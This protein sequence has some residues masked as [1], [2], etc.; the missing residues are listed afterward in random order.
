MCPY[1]FSAGDLG[2]RQWERMYL[3]FFP[4]GPRREI[5][6]NVLEQIIGERQ[7]FRWFSSRKDAHFVY[8]ATLFLYLFIFWCGDSFIGRCVIMS[9][10][11][12]GWR[13]N[14]FP[15]KQRKTHVSADNVLV[16]LLVKQ[17]D[18]VELFMVVISDLLSCCWFSTTFNFS[19]GAYEKKKKGK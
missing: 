19:N 3:E 1:V 5:I 9:D 18:G 12:I 8:I 2:E 4:F 15:L 11:S 16:L 14:W 6:H 7:Y 10:S 17:I 13:P